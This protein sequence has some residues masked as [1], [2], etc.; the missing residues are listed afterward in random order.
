MPRRIAPDEESRF[1][2]LRHDFSCIRALSFSLD[3]KTL[4][5][6]IGN[7]GVWFWDVASRKC[8]NNIEPDLPGTDAFVSTVFSPDGKTAASWTDRRIV[9]WDTARRKILSFLTEEDKVYWAEFSPDGR[10][11]SVLIQT[12]W[13]NPEGLRIW[14]LGKRTRVQTFKTPPGLRGLAA[15]RGIKTPLMVHSHRADG[16]DKDFGFT[17]VDAFT[18]KSVLTCE[19]LM[20]DAPLAFCI[21]MNRAE[22]IVASA[23][24]HSAIQLW[25]R[26]S[27]KRLARFKAP[28][29]ICRNLGFSPDGQILAAFYLDDDRKPREGGFLIYDV[30]SGKLRA[31]IK[32]PDG[33]RAWAFSPDSRLLAAK[34]D[35]EIRVWKIPEPWRRGK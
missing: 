27:G 1:G 29:H 23:G 13:R 6:T 18:G 8:V 4:Y 12:H 21:A 22:T 2:F 5:T 15:P 19:W 9:L 26:N 14:D 34:N 20:K 7:R 16:P 17:L 35:R 28:P 31:E 25:D 33:F 3:G 11:L 32:E 24:D 30:P 10:T